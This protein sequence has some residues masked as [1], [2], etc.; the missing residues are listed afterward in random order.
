MHN[1][2]QIQT[3]MPQS[4]QVVTPNPL[5]NLTTLADAARMK[6]EG[7][8]PESEEEVKPIVPT[9][10]TEYPPDLDTAESPVKSA[11]QQQQQQQPLPTFHDMFP[12]CNTQV[13]YSTPAPVH[14]V[15][16]VNNNSIKHPLPPVNGFG[17]QQH[18][19]PQQVNLQPPQPQQQPQQTQPQIQQVQVNNKSSTDAFVQCDDE[20][21]P[22]PEL[23]DVIDYYLCKGKIF[24]CHHCDIIF[25]ERAMY[26]LHVSLHGSESPWQCAICDKQCTDK[27]DFTLHFINQK[28][29]R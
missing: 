9:F 13:V 7:E 6:S 1:E 27:N 25:F 8:K 28:H 15:M 5:D 19:M 11:Q 4:R 17:N 20:E 10:S 12:Q 24:R 14:H 29:E 23:E 22:M 26:F 3:Q 16:E 18:Q 2:I 21:G